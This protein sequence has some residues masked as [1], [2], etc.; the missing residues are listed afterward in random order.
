VRKDFIDK[1][2]VTLGGDVNHDEQTSPYEQEVK[3]EL[4][5][6]A[7][8]QRRADYAFPLPGL[9]FCLFCK[10]CELGSFYY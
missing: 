4:P 9:T 5:V 10:Y 1:F 3:A 2:F 7:G 8:G 6:S